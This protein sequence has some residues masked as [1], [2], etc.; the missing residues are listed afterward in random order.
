MTMIDMFG[1]RFNCQHIFHR[2]QPFPISNDVIRVCRDDISR[3]GFCRNP[4]ICVT[5]AS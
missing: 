3:T 5:I 1:A 4:T 2:F